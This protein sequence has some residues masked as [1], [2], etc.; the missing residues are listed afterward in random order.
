MLK[1]HSL[2]K[3]RSEKMIN[4]IYCV[5]EENEDGSSIIEFFNTRREDAIRYYKQRLAICESI[6]KTWQKEKGVN[7]CRWSQGEKVKEL[8]A[9]KVEVED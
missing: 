1:I 9:K 3:K 6:Y 5:N 2:W 4:T 8:Y 7:Y